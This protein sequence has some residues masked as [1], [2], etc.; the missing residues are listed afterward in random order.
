[1]LDLSAVAAACT[2]HNRHYSGTRT[3]PIGQIRGSEGRC[4]DFDGAFHP[5]KTHNEERWVSVAGA[6]L[7]GTGLPA[8]ELIQLGEVYFV[9]DGH[10]RISVAAA[11]G[12][13]EIDAVVTIWHVTEPVQ[14]NRPAVGHAEPHRWRGFLPRLVWRSAAEA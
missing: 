3:V 12:Q 7:R 9:R 13:Q 10:H 1:L 6:Q 2:I 4:E 5:L 11:L 14:D 8:V